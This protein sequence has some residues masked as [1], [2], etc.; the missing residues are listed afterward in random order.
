MNSP[1]STSDSSSWNHAG[2]HGA[3]A[4]DVTTEGGVDPGSISPQQTRLRGIDINTP[5]TTDN[6]LARPAQIDPRYFAP[7]RWQLRLQAALSTY[8][9]TP[10]GVVCEQ[11][12]PLVPITFNTPC[13]YVSKI[14]NMIDG[15]L[16]YA[17]R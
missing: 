10:R 4:T 9:C 15:Q 6:A 7:T 3:P 2:S 17:N 16:S 5:E 1:H 11:F 12:V 14:P 8:V 13:R